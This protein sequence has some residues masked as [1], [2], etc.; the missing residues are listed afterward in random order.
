MRIHGARVLGSCEQ[1]SALVERYAVDLVAV[2]I[3]AEQSDSFRRILNLCEQTSAQVKIAPHALAVLESRNG[4]GHLRDVTIE[5]LLGRAPVSI[6]EEACRRVLGGKVVMVTGAAGSIG[7]EVCRQAV[8]F[9]PRRVVAVDNNETG[10]YELGLELQQP[11]AEAQV[12]ELVLA[13][14]TDAARLDEV[15]RRFRP[16]V[17]FHG[18]AYK[19]VPLVET[20]VGEAI[21]TNVGGTLQTAALS[22]RYGVERFIYISSDKAVYPVSVM[23]ATKRVGEL[24]VAGMGARADAR[25]A[26]SAGSGNGDTLFACVRFGNVLNSRG[27]VVPTFWKQIDQGGPVTVTHPDMTRYF[28]SLQ[29]AVSLIIQAAGFTTGDDIFVLDMGE[30]VRIQDLAQ[31]MIRLRG[32]RVGKD[33]S[34]VH[35]GI[36]PGEKLFELLTCPACEQREATAHERIYRVRRKAPSE[37]STDSSAAQS[38]LEEAESVV[39]LAKQAEHE[40]VLRQKLFDIAQEPC[41]R[42][43]GQVRQCERELEAEGSR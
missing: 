27:S 13:D 25:A 7:S 2:T 38:V 9:S 35:T 24:V 41:R 18:A 34:I 32:L 29:E 14:V 10:L 5:D 42:D 31:R 4:L 33:V 16:E 11:S 22:E 43:C 20:A 23:G 26:V 12:V 30:E 6:D 1:I 39:T 21:K 15:F 19:H 28:M 37:E 17:V 8:R 36:R 40:T 3:R